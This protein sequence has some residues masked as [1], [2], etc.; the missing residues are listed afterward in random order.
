MAL[1]VSALS[2]SLAPSVVIARPGTHL[3]SFESADLSTSGT[4]GTGRGR[5]TEQRGA[6]LQLPAV[7]DLE[8]L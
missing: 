2:L 8:L 5:V 1:S 7:L 6:P 4:G 3:Y